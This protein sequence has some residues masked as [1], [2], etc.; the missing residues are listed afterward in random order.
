MDVTTPEAQM[1]VIRRRAGLGASNATIGAESANS[2]SPENPIAQGGTDLMTNPPSGGAMGAPSDRAMA[3][4]QQEKG[5]AERITDSLIKRQ[6][7]L[8]KQAMAQRGGM[9]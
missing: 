6:R 5:E 1:E 9:I 7:A 4:Q 3:R 2:L 8:E